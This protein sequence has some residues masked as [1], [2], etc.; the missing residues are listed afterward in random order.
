LSSAVLSVAA[1]VVSVPLVA[2]VLSARVPS[3]SLSP[4]PPPLLLSVVVG[5]QGW[6]VRLRVVRVAGWVMVGRVCWRR[7]VMVVGRFW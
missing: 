3:A 6:G 5:G 4:V 7:A 2:S 1:F